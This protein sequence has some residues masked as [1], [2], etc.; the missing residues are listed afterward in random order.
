[1]YCTHTVKKMT[2]VAPDTVELQTLTF[3]GFTR[4]RC[5]SRFDF[6]QPETPQETKQCLPPP[7]RA[8]SFEALI[9]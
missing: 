9:S 3:G 8:R 5:L 2:L 6:L 7:P 4:T 1:M